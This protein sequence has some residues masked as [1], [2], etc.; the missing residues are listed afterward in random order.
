MVREGHQLKTSSEVLQSTHCNNPLITHLSVPET[1]GESKHKWSMSPV[2]SPL[3]TLTCNS[4][5]SAGGAGAQRKRDFFSFSPELWF[6]AIFSQ[7]PLLTLLPWGPHNPG[8]PNSTV[9]I[10][11]PYCPARADLYVWDSSTQPRCHVWLLLP[12][13]LLPPLWSSPASLGAWAH[14]L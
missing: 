3:H 4:E 6:S 14:P 1:P 8:Q 11:L 9:S 7:G 5:L 12:L 13:K 2:P 10:S